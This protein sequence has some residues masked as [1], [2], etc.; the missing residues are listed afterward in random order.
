MAEKTNVEMLVCPLL[1]PSV[2]LHVLFQST[3]PRCAISCK[4]LPGHSVDVIIMA[5]MAVV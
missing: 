1:Q 2:C 5:E 3:P 4:A